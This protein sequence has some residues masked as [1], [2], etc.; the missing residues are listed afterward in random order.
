[1]KTDNRVALVTGSARGLG[2]AIGRRLFGRNPSLALAG[3]HCG[4]DRVGRALLCLGLS[5]GGQRLPLRRLGLRASLRLEPRRGGRRLDRRCNRG[6][7]LL[8]RLGMGRLERDLPGGHLGVQSGLCGS[9][10]F[11][12]RAHCR[13]ET[14]GA[15]RL[16]SA[17]RRV[18][19]QLAP[20]SLGSDGRA[21]LALALGAR[22]GHLFGQCGSPLDCC[23]LACAGLRG[24][25]SCLVSAR[26]LGTL[27]LVFYASIRQGGVDRGRHANVSGG[28]R[29]CRSLL[30]RCCEIDLGL[31]THARHRA[32]H[33]HELVPCRARRRRR[34]RRA[35][36]RHCFG[37]R[38][39]R[40]SVRV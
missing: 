34:R 17:K 30:Q 11:S 33:R 10:Y 13:G 2:K 4:G 25:Q 8:L 9:L 38:T 22:G 1:M 21:R 20:R 32:D 31:R 14:F 3:G 23:L 37:A 7:Q 26:D 24:D 36:Q 29:R 16:G 40:R 28:G 19:L 5:L 18:R 35:L 12:T 6:R 15:G 39:R 27:G